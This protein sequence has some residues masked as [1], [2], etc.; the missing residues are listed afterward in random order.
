MAKKTNSVA[1]VRI[2]V[3]RD[4]GRFVLMSRKRAIG[5]PKHNKLEFPGGHLD[6]DESP[7]AALVR[8]LREEEQSGILAIEQRLSVRQ[9]R[10]ARL[11][12]HRF[13]A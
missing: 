3:L 12:S 4:C 8:E 7:I 1:K 13:R 10:P 6:G 9:P 5:K 11:P 2:I